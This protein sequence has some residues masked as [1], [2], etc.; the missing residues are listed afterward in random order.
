MFLTEED[1][2]MGSKRHTAEEIVSKLR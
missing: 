2:E 1:I